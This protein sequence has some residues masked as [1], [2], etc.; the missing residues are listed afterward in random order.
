MADEVPALGVG[1]CRARIA[2][3]DDSVA[4]WE[5]LENNV[6]AKTSTGPLAGVTVGIKDI[7]AVGGM[8]LRYGS[9]IFANQ[10]ADTDAESVARLRAAGAVILGKTVTTEFATYHPDK[11]RNPHNP[12][13]TPGGSSSGSAAAV[14]DCQVDAALGTQTAGSVIR[15]ASFCGVLGYKPSYGR[16]PTGGML[17]VS[18]ELDHIGLFA[19]NIETLAALDA[20]L[21]GGGDIGLPHT[22]EQPVIGVCRTPWWDRADAAMQAAILDASADL[23]ACGFEVTSVPLPADFAPLVEI[24]DKVMARDAADSLGAY[25][26]QHPD[27][28]SAALQALIDKGRA[29]SADAD[30][31]NR[32]AFAAA[33]TLF[34][35]TVEGDDALLMP[36]APGP[37]PYGLSATGDPL[38]NRMTTL[39]GVPALG[40]PFAKTGEGLPLGLQL[41]A[42]FGS[43]RALLALGARLIPAISRLWPLQPPA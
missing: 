3:R 5:H 39:L 19:R 37:A 16:Y 12:A 38:F 8:P 7:I 6:E 11:T 1:Q 32:D 10:I 29:I 18:P 31:R 9:P 25:A 35:A 40:F 27:K 42:S 26:D 2:A 30:R 43:D 15:P 22:T 20:I 17:I 21:G 13:H 28:V 24:H 33:R 4:A 36:G 34:A 41:V 23:A 14:A